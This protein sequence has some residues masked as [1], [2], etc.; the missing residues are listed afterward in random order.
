MH[1]LVFILSRHVK[2]ARKVKGLS[3]MSCAVTISIF[4]YLRKHGAEFVGVCFSRNA[5]VAV[6][7]Y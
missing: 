5:T 7:I 2:S 6:A 3:F 4:N 1:A